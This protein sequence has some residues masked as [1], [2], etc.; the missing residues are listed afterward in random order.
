MPRWRVARGLQRI[1]IGIVA[2][3]AFT[4]CGT[5]AA[6]ATASPSVD[7]QAAMLAFTQCMRQHGVNV[8]DPAG[9]QAHITVTLPNTQGSAFQSAQKACQKYLPKLGGNGS[10]TPDPARTEQFLKF[11]QCMRAHG[12]NMPDPQTSNGGFALSAGGPG[13]KIDPNSAAFKSAQS[14]CQKYLP[15][16]PVGSSGQGLTTNGGGSGSG[17]SISGSSGQ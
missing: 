10:A 4:A 13:D 17:L 1:G 12:I 5:A 15:G 9:G 14:A 8:P 7:P 6:A 16:K 2:M 11:A 3:G